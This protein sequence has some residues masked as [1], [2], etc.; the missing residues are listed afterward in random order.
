[1]HSCT[2]NQLYIVEKFDNTDVLSTVL[3]I[4]YIIHCGWHLRTFKIT[5]EIHKLMKTQVLLLI[6]LV[7]LLRYIRLYRNSEA[8]LKCLLIKILSEI[9]M[10]RKDKC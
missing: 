8:M 7:K 3:K 6:M 1:M 10:F 5:L 9:S 4:V 2:P